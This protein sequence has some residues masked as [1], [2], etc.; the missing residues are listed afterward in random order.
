MVPVREEEAR[1]LRRQRTD[2]IL[3]RNGLPPVAKGDMDRLKAMYGGHRR[4]E[5][6]KSPE[7]LAAEYAARPVRLSDA[8]IETL[9]PK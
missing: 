8:A 9:K 2:A 3:A 5:P 6:G 1:R 4:P 7:E